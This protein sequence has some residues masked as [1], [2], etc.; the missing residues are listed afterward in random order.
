[1]TEA[2]EE[3][4]KLT[5]DRVEG[6]SEGQVRHW[7]NDRRRAVRYFVEA[8]GDLPLAD[9]ARP[10]AL[11]FRAWWQAR[12]EAK[13]GDPETA[14]KSLGHVADVHSTVSDLL[15]LGLDNP[16]RGLR[17]KARLHRKKVPPFSV[18]FLRAKLLAPGALDRMNE[19]A[20]DA[21]LVMVNTGARPSEIVGALP[22]D[23][24]VLDN[25]PHLAVLPRPGRSLKT[26]QSE[27]EI[28]LVGVSLEAARRIVARGGF[29]RYFLKGDGWSAA[30]N[31]FLRE[32]GLLET[33]DH[34]AYSLR[35]AFEDRLLEQGTDDRLRAELMGHKYSRPAYGRGGS[36]AIKARAV[37]GI[38]L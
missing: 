38:A 31:K 33:D 2:L 17:L 28:P 5:R 1:M 9:I 19:E 29:S 7:Q 34:T 22:E 16:F 21:L 26:A 18:E 15:A 24:R 23:F 4:F 3:F 36:L 32:K 6:K 12:I 11:K 10:E 8:A 25:L 35:H 30:V 13:G 14:N 20:R 37:E 27:R